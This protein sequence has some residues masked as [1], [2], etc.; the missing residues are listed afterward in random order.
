MK[1]GRIVGDSDGVEHGGVATASRH[2]MRDCDVMSVIGQSLAT[3]AGSR[4]LAE[5]LVGMKIMA[6]ADR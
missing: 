2:L 1:Q 4:L 6:W 3:L 5:G